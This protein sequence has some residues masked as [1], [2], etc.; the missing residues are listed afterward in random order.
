MAQEEDGV[1]PQVQQAPAREHAH[2]PAPALHARRR[3]LREGMV[4]GGVIGLGCPLLGELLLLLLL[5]A[6]SGG[7]GRLLELCR[8]L[9]LLRRGPVACGVW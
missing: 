6:V 9:F 1:P 2:L 4:V 5:R 8:L 3:P 7:G